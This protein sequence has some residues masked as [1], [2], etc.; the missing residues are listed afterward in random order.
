M[1]T[2]TVDQGRED[3]LDAILKIAWQW[4]A[5]WF[6]TQRTHWE[7]TARA[8]LEEWVWSSWLLRNVNGNERLEERASV[9]IV[10]R[11]PQVM[12]Q[13]RRRG[14]K[15]S[16]DFE[17]TWLEEW[18]C[19]SQKGSQEMELGVRGKDGEWGR[20]GVP[21]WIL[22]LSGAGGLGPPWTPRSPPSNVLSSWSFSL[23]TTTFMQTTHLNPKCTTMVNLCVIITGSQ[24]AEIFGQI[25]FWVCL[26]GCLFMRMTFEAADW[27]KQMGLSK[28]GGP[29]PINWR[30]DCVKGWPF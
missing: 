2:F 21:S 23:L 6:G 24:D 19:H 30:S 11:T 1:D 14:A 26:W 9:E 29:H 10:Y 27:V 17:P 18:W 4:H 12:R 28:G 25:L 8:W 3:S 20:K 13:K 22:W 7:N 16:P 15:V 5:R